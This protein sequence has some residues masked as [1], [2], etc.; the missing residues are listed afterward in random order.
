M[1]YP[2]LRRGIIIVWT[3]NSETLKK[4][5]KAAPGNGAAGSFGV[6][7]KRAE[8]FVQR[9]QQGRR[10]GILEVGQR[11]AAVSILLLQCLY[12]G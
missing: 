2:R 3:Y 8:L 7:S 11:M 10:R 9:F 1:K 12:I 4:K 6:K 5:Q